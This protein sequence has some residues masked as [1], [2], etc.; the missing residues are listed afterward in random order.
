LI[1]ERIIGRNL[2][3][4]EMVDHIDGNGLNNRRANLRL[5]NAMQN[6][7]NRGVQANNR[8]GFKGVSWSI[9]H[10][11]WFAF[12]TIDGKCVNLGGFDTPEAAHKIYAEF[13]RKHLG[14]FA[15]DGSKGQKDD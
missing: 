8:S 9:R 6:Q 11:R 4:G 13:V 5:A 15:N 3:P 14:E 7:A 10:K 12:A 2:E 1:L